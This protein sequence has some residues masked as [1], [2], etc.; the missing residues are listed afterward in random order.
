MIVEQHQVGAQ[1]LLPPVALGSQDLAH[2]RQV[3]RLE[4]AQKQNGNVARDAV[5]P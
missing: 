4:D 2:D 1:S 5:T 3:V